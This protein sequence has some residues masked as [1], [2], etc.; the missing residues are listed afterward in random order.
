VVNKSL[1][2]RTLDAIESLDLTGGFAH[3]VPDVET[4]HP[5]HAARHTQDFLHETLRAFRDHVAEI[6][7]SG[8]LTESGKEE[9]L[10]A[11]CQA[12]LARVQEG[13]IRGRVLRPLE[14]KISKAEAALR[15]PKNASPEQMLLDYL[16]ESEVRAHLRT[17]NDQERVVALTHAVEAGDSTTVHAVLNSPKLFGL[18]D[19]KT[20]G[21]ARQRWESRQNPEAAQNLDQLRDGLRAAENALEATVGMLRQAGGIDTEQDIIARIK[22]TNS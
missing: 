18:V 16:R 12:A 6:Q 22:S 10:E 3:R 11:A 2:K 19:D 1:L 5:L 4:T 20:L 9:D 14:D 21:E 17:M 13:N 15:A 7:S 8:R